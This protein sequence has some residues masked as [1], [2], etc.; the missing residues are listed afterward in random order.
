[1]RHILMFEVPKLKW[2]YRAWQLRI[3]AVS[4]RFGLPPYKPRS[5]EP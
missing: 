3:V 5:P 4:L 1:M 2:S